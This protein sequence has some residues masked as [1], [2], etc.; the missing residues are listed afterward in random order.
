MKNK[1]FHKCGAHLPV[2][3]LRQTLDYYRD[4]FGFYEEWIEGKIDGGI[5]R[6]DMRL[7]FGEDAAYAQLINS[8]TARFNLIWFVDNIDEVYAEY[9][10]RGIEIVNSLKN[11]TYGMR[12][13]AIIDLNGYYIRIAE[14]I[15]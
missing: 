12:E 13:F 14:G 3:N 15:D 2:I 7:L 11:Y 5:R 10:E 6:D 4:K 8:E 9:Q 1:R